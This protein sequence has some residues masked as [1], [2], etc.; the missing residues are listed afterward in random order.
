MSSENYSAKNITILKGLDPVKERPGMYTKTES[1]NHI[2]EEVIDNACDEALGGYASKIKI[3]KLKTGEIVVED[4]GR[5]IP[6]DIHPEEG[7]P[8]V[9][10]IFTMLHSGGK[11]NK[12]SED[13]PYA[14]AGG[15]H[16]VGVSVT[17]A[18]SERL[19]IVVK[20]SGKVYELEFSNG[21]LVK[22]LKEIGETNRTGTKVTIEPNPKYFDE[23]EVNIK[24]I[25]ELL[26]SKAILLSGVEFELIIEK[27]NSENEEYTWL[28]SEEAIIY[29]DERYIEEDHNYAKGEGASWAVTWS[30]EAM[31]RKSFVNLIG[32]PS[33][34]THVNGLRNALFEGI[35]NYTEQHALLP[36]GLKLVAEDVF[37]KVS[38]VLSTKILDPEFQGQTKERLNNRT[39]HSLLSSIIKDQFETWLNNNIE[40]ANRISEI[41]ISSAKYRSKKSDKQVELKTGGI[42]HLPG[43]LTDCETKNPEDAEL[44]IVEGDS[45]GGSAKQGRDRIFQAILP[46]K[47]KVNNTWEM[48]NGDLL[49]H[50]EIQNISIAIGVR[51]H[52]LEEKDVDLSKLRYHKICILADADVDGYHIQVLLL[53]LFGKHYHKLIDNGHI[54]IAQP[55]LYKIE[56]KQK[57]KIK[58]VGSGGKFYALD[59]FELEQ[60]KKK[61]HKLKL[62]EEDYSTSRFKG[63]GEMNPD[64]LRE[65]TLNPDTRRLKKVVWDDEFQTT[66]ESLDML[67][68]KKRAEDRK[69]WIEEDGI[70]IE[71]DL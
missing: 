3:R 50:E 48:D 40:E 13:N 32:T 64:Q 33:G 20:K 28:F 16:G 54:Y 8:A 66:F 46:A 53:T 25:K 69:K 12:D 30:D 45:A 41:C 49:S 26:E 38:Y 39:A 34:G 2:V 62:T 35:K 22:E 60:L 6:T 59:D 51:P 52:T 18:L 4:N 19:N 24:E 37:G 15:L 58:I 7:I 27:E 63:L 9:V 47:G 17:N 1:P 68:S 21:E 42:T 56:V 29:A 36:R 67:M 43:K 65:T 61:F 11:F 71:E 14:F 31:Y 10:V 44:F 23:P 55:P 5:G 57:S 70:F